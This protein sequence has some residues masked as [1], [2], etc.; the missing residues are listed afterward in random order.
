MRPSL[1]SLACRGH[2]QLAVFDPAQAEHVIGQMLHLAGWSLHD[3][4]FKAVLLVEM[5]MRRRQDISMMVVLRLGQLFRE[6]RSMVVV[7]HGKGCNHRLVAAYLIGHKRIP[8]EIAQSFGTIAVTTFG[9]QLVK[10][11]QNS[12]SIET[13]VLTSS[14]IFASSRL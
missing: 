1:Q 4:H 6:I 5:H 14:A 10:A 7:N 8:N 11:L 13:P 2:Y 9:N 3:D 12:R